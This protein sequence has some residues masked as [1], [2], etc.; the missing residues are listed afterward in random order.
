[1]KRVSTVFFIVVI[2]SVTALLGWN[3]VLLWDPNPSDEGVFE[4]RV[5]EVD[6][7]DGSVIRSLGSVTVPAGSTDSSLTVFD[8]VNQTGVRCFRVSAVNSVAEGPLSDMVCGPRPSKVTGE[9]I[10]N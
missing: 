3:R 1:M 4:Y 2:L 7:L 10:G 9:R 5:Y 8:V 6:G